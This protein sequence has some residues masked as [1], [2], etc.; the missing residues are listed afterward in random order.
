MRH[1]AGQPADRLHPLGMH[2]VSLGP[3]LFRQRLADA[4]L[5]QLVDA[6]EVFLGAFGLGDVDVGPDIALI[7][8]GRVEP[9]QGLA[10][11]PALAQRGV[12]RADDA[13][14]PFAPFDGRVEGFGE[15]LDVVRMNQPVPALLDVPF[16]LNAEE[17]AVATVHKARPA[18]GVQ[19][20]DQGRRAVGDG[21]EPGL[22][23]RQPVLGQN[24]RRLIPQRQ[25]RTDFLTIR[26]GHRAGVA[27]RD[28]LASVR[29]TD[30]PTRVGDGF[31][32]QHSPDQRQIRRGVGFAGLGQQVIGLRI[33]F[34]RHVELR[35]AVMSDRRLVDEDDPAVRVGDDDP[36]GQ[37]AQDGVAFRGGGGQTGI[38]LANVGDI[39]RHADKPLERSP[40]SRAGAGEGLQPAV[41]TV[42]AQ[43]A[44]FQGEGLAGR[45]AGDRFLQNALLV[46]G[47][48]D[49]PPI[50]PERLVIGAAAEGH[51]GLVD[52]GAGTIRV[53]DPD[54]DR[55]RVGDRPEPGFAL[56]QLGFRSRAFH[57]RPCLVRDLGD[58]LDLGVRPD[59]GRI[60]VYMQEPAK[61]AQPHDG[62]RDEGLHAD[63]LEAG[64]R[65]GRARV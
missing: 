5:E 62:G 34:R 43:I 33:V 56:A 44:R 19:H 63:G 29:S 40:R 16:G 55:R 4:F 9:G 48:D 6:F 20:P 26:T 25:H 64:R 30:A 10:A 24:P 57:V 39:E 12:A 8:A 41:D 23:F 7:V 1:A 60:G 53:G 37:L 50:R 36:L 18:L 54:Q 2:Q 61:F 52:E 49:R 45:L 13:F 42:V 46:V 38:G 51:I 31:P 3:G 58:Q 47:M 28:D 59:A 22:G 14:E 35:H 17:G 27:D 65:A 11:K 21:A 32:V 15:G